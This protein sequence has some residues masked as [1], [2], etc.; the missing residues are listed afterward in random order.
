MSFLSTWCITIRSDLSTLLT[1]AAS[2][3]TY[4]TSLLDTWLTQNPAGCWGSPIEAADPLWAEIVN[5]KTVKE[6]GELLKTQAI[7][8]GKEVR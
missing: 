5:V 4:L 2:T 8:P 3:S 6:L 1:T 7:E